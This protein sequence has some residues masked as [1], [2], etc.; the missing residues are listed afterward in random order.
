MKKTIVSVVIDKI[1]LRKLILGKKHLENM[2]H[3]GRRNVEGST[4]YCKSK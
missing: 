4:F 2:D 1:C 3:L